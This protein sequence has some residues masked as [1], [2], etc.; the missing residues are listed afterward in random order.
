MS[1]KTPDFDPSG[2]YFVFNTYFTE[3]KHGIRMI[4]KVA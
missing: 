2:L 4:K 3:V 1:Q